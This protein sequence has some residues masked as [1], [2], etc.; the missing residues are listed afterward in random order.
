MLLNGE[1]SKENCVK[2]KRRAYIV[3]ALML[4]IGFLSLSMPLMASFAIETLLGFFLLAVGLSNAFSAYGA[5]REGV[6]PWHHI[7]MAVISVL[8]GIVFLTH[9][10]AGVITLSMILA[11]YFLADGVYKVVQFFRLRK[12][13]G[14]FWMLL[15]GALGILLAFLMWRNFF[16]CAT[17]IGIIL[18]F[19]LIFSGVSLI[20]IG[21][22]FSEMSKNL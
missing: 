16:E 2:A 12:V 20:M 6:T 11:A 4:I 18:G 22:G 13:G 5:F 15:S 14:S 1:F 7:F 21:R 10:V 19:D 17:V 8:A 3:G 9:P